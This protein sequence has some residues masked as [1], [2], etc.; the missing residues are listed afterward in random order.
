MSL[1]IVT[2]VFVQIMIAE[3]SSD[4][5]REVLEEVPEM[6]DEPGALTE[7]AN[8][9]I[10]F[11]HV[12]FSYAGEGG[13]LSLKDVSLHIKSGQIVGIIGG[14][15]S[16]K[17]TLVQLIPRLYDVVGGSVKV[18]GVDVRRYNWK[19]FG[20]RCLWC[21]RRMCCLPEASRKISAGEM[22]TPAMKRCRESADL[23]RRMDLSRNFRQ[24]TI[25]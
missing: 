8:G 4:R 10:D 19:R 17:S 15:G 11:E 2:F 14:T 12:D 5:I 3:A 23:R 9:D 7:V 1:M 25:R 24:D 21:C 13:N 22:K 6:E 16:A 18:G 20:T